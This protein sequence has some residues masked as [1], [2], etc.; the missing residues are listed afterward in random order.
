LDKLRLIGD[1][2]EALLVLDKELAT[3]VF[4]NPFS[5]KI[6]KIRRTSIRGKNETDKV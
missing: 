5:T 6:S 1:N 2:K 3:R 4:I